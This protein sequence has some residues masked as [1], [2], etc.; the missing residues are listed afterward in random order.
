[1]SIPAARHASLSVTMLRSTLIICR[2][3]AAMQVIQASTS[4]VPSGIFR[5]HGPARNFSNLTRTFITIAAI[6]L[7]LLTALIVLL[8]SCLA[9]SSYCVCPK[10]D[11]AQNW[12]I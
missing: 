6:H 11:G 12:R 9:C 2:H 7:H 5:N 3:A 10:T 1:M 8:P 4:D